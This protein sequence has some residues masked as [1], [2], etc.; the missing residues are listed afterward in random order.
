[1]IASGFPGQKVIRVNTRIAT[2]RMMGIIQNR[3]FT[4]YRPMCSSFFMRPPQAGAGARIE[5]QIKLIF[6]SAPCRS[7]ELRGHKIRSSVVADR[8][9]DHAAVRTVDAA[10]GRHNQSVGVAVVF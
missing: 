4:M 3:R 5:L 9:V 8:G 6:F 10:D 2:L 1:M 7:L